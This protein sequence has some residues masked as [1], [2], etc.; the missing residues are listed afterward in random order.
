[1]RYKMKKRFVCM[2]LK[3]V[4]RED[5]KLVTVI[6]RIVKQGTQLAIKQGLCIWIMPSLQM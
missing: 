1:M 6:I 3:P 4:K 5:F 2:L